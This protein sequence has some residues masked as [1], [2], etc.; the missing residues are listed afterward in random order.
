MKKLLFL[1]IFSQIGF[2]QSYL[3]SNDFSL[4][5]DLTIKAFFPVH[6]GNNFLAKSNEADVGIGLFADLIK[7]NEFSIGIGYDYTYYSI[8]D[9]TRAGNIN[10][11]RLNCFYGNLSY[12]IALNEDLLLIPNIGL[13]SAT[14]K[15]QSKTRSFGSQNGNETRFGISVNYK[16]SD[17]LVAVLGI[18]Y[19]GTKYIINT[20]PEFISFYD[21]SK[22]LQI[23]LGLKFH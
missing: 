5:T 18:N 8:I 3:S 7:Y 10:S 16:L 12:F 11:S 2:C 20:S 14:I 19:V 17:S 15:F 23:S 1:L 6:F 21:N 13:G 9:I 22:I 4:D